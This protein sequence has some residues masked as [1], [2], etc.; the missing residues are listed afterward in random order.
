MSESSNNTDLMSPWQAHIDRHEQSSR[1]RA[2]MAQ[3]H[4][5]KAQ[6][7]AAMAQVSPW[8]FWYRMKAKHHQSIVKD[9]ERQRQ[10]HDATILRYQ[11][12]VNKNALSATR[13]KLPGHTKT[14]WY[15]GRRH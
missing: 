7:Y 11:L 13:T 1:Y 15:A 10:L 8:S 4:Q 12:K 9:H 5:K 2:E 3:Y 6:Y 14:A